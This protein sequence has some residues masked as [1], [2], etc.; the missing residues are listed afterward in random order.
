MFQII[1]EWFENH[2]SMGCRC[3]LTTLVKS[4]I[5]SELVESKSTLDVSKI[6]RKYHQT[7]KTFVT[8]SYKY[9]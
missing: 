9:M 8:S 1:D 7:M 5:T 3:D 6:Y 4:V 2:V